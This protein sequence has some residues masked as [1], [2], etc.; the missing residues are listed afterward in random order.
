MTLNRK[1]I[2]AYIILVGIILYSNYLFIKGI[3]YNST[4]YSNYFTNLFLDLILIII[5]SFILFRLYSILILDVKQCRGKNNYKKLLSGVFF[6]L[7]IGL[8]SLWFLI[9]KVQNVV[10]SMMDLPRVINKNPIVDNEYIKSKYSWTK[11]I[12]GKNNT[13]KVPMITIV[14]DKNTFS[15]EDYGN[16]EFLTRENLMV[17]IYYLPHTKTVLKITKIKEETW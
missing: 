12:H 1:K 11:V 7:V 14:T 16:I 13:A 2:I 8:A 6:C 4:V 3:S 17:T 10:N 15:F 5:I 9:P